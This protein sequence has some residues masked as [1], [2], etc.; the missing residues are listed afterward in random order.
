MTKKSLLLLITIIG[1]F[2]CNRN[3]NV[4]HYYKPEMPLNF[5][6]VTGSTIKVFLINK[7]DSLLFDLPQNSTLEIVTLKDSIISLQHSIYEEIINEKIDFFSYQKYD[8]STVILIDKKKDIFLK[9]VDI[10]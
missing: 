9:D 6:N 7:D 8:S 5:K 10:I 3:D 1:L 4:T 2:S